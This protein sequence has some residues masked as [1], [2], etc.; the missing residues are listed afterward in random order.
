VVRRKSFAKM[1]CPIARSLEETGDW[2]SMLILR[3]AF[4]GTRRFQDFQARLEIAPNTLTRRLETL[5]E[6]GLLRR[7]IYSE[8][9]PR[10]EYELTD[11]GLDFL[12]VLL[13]LTAWGNR[14]LA[15]EGTAIECADPETGRPFDP[16]VVDRETGR[17]LRAGTVALRPGPAAKPGLQRAL[18]RGVLLGGSSPSQ[19]NS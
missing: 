16:I 17:E 4:I 9:P 12:P 1:Q 3:S 6:H 11:K 2:W 5:I 14:W 10:E 8:R 13:A 15:P 18:E 7:R 19:K